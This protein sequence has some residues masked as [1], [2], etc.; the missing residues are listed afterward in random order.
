MAKITIYTGQF[1]GYCM[2]AKALL[3]KKGAAYREI[4]VSSNPAARAEM[5]EAASGR[6]TV[7]QIFISGRHVGG[8]DELY[9]LE[10]KGALDPLL[11]AG[12]A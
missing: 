10:S 2:R 1:C 5:I 4:D 8:C 11:A 9:A 6:Y 3:D 7:P 12:A